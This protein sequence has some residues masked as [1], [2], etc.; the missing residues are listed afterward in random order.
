MIRPGLR[1][2]VAGMRHGNLRQT[3]SQGSVRRADP[4]VVDDAGQPWHDGFKIDPIAH[5]CSG[6]KSGRHLIGAG[7]VRRP[8]PSLPGR[9]PFEHDSF[10]SNAKKGRVVAEQAAEGDEDRR[11]ILSRRL[12]LSPVAGEGGLRADGR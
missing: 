6:G 11:R 1:L 7:L 10:G 2:L 5:L 8:A 3:V 12:R 9:P 4:A